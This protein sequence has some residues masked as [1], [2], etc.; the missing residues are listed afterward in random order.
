MIRRL[1]ALSI[2]A[3][4]LSA[5][6]GS[7]GPERASGIIDVGEARPGEVVQLDEYP[8][9]FMRLD[10][11][12]G[13]DTYL[14]HGMRPNGSA[15]APRPESPERRPWACTCFASMTSPDGPLFG[16]NFDFYHR[17]SLLLATSP[18]GAFA[19]ISMVD[20][21]YLGFGGTARLDELQAQK[22]RLDRAPHYPFDGVNT[23]GVAMGLMAVP[24]AEP[25]FDPS[26]VSLYDLA[27]I[28]LVLDY[29]R[30]ANHAVE[31]MQGFN[32]RT[33]QYPVHFLI[34][35]PGGTTV[36]VEYLDHD[37]KVTRASEP[38]M[39]ATNFVVFGSE[40]PLRTPCWRYDRAYAALRAQNGAL[41]T[42]ACLD[43]LEAVSQDITM[44]SVVY[45]MRGRSADV[46]VGR[47][48][49][50]VYRILM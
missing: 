38:Y 37:V 10:G 11:G 6:A 29:A 25:P 47:R 35:D 28:R 17:A 41:S 22:G 43:L 5:C 44:W 27:L 45:N 26:K 4:A 48:Y 7:E 19:S 50:S 12:Y 39:V 32:Y 31:L 15:P 8:L 2:A 42:G 21:H 33:N 46:T 16:R 49:E 9:Y 20:L 34:S 3:A 36:L 18:P 1:C 13:F 14:T 30:D 24:S 23:N 40:A